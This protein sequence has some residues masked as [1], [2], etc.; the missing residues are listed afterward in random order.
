MEEERLS[1]CIRRKSEDPSTVSVDNQQRRGS[2]AT[3]ADEVNTIETSA[4]DSK[5]TAA[6]VA[7]SDADS[8]AVAAATTT[9]DEG[10]AD[11]LGQGP[12]DDVSSEL[13]YP[14]FIET[15]F[16]RLEQ[17]TRP[18]SW[19]LKAITWPYPF[20]VVDNSRR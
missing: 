8:T 18:R 11:G 16:F 13:P 10:S 14:G 17:T 20:F 9:D 12:S 5:G 15:V 2:P 1:S 6:A 7:A 19:C 4:A 3:T